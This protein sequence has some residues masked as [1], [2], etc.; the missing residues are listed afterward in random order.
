MLTKRRPIKARAR[1]SRRT[2]GAINFPQLRREVLMLSNM[3]LIIRDSRF[4]REARSGSS[5]QSVA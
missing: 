5:A 4:F 3:G 2:P 1:I